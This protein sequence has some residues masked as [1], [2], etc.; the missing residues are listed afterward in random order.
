MSGCAG[1][2]GRGI[3]SCWKMVQESYNHQNTRK[4][5]ICFG[6]QTTYTKRDNTMFSKFQYIHCKIKDSTILQNT[7]ILNHLQ[8]D[9]GFIIFYLVSS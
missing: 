8:R 9:L 4:K 3:I 2:M 7:K 5:G 6:G 1:A